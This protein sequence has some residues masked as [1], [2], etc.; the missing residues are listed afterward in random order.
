M[1]GQRLQ[2]ADCPRINACDRVASAIVAVLARGFARSSDEGT[3]QS[4]PTLPRILPDQRPIPKA[5]MLQCLKEA[6][7]P[8]NRG[9]SSL[10]NPLRCRQA[11]MLRF[12]LSAAMLVAHDW[13]SGRR[14]MTPGPFPKSTSHSPLLSALPLSRSLQNYP[15]HSNEPATL[16]HL[17][18]ANLIPLKRYNELR[19]I[20]SAIAACLAAQR[21]L[22][23]GAGGATSCSGA[24][25]WLADTGTCRVSS[26]I[27][28]YCAINGNWYNALLLMAAFSG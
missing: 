4:P 16:H 20:A 26:A 28:P 22:R 2:R 14:R 23:A 5:Q 25:N 17:Q 12:P 6:C 3:T 27:D 7:Q 8:Y 9:L 24:M 21:S 10:P 15:G 19:C 13:R 11:G 1:S 18:P